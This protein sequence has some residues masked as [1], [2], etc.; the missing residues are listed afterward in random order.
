M[1]EHWREVLDTWKENIAHFE[2][3]TSDLEVRHA[4]EIKALVDK[5]SRIVGINFRYVRISELPIPV[6]VIIDFN[7]RNKKTELTGWRK[8]KERLF[9]SKQQFSNVEDEEESDDEEEVDC[10]DGVDNVNN[11]N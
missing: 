2:E 7:S 11:Y 10:V 8:L 3:F 5:L 6:K 9:G 1:I 4:T